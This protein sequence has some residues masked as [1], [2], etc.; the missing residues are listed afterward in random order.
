[1]RRLL[2]ALIH[3]IRE[4]RDGLWRNPALSLLSSLSI[5]AALYVVGLFFLIAFN[6]DGY[7]DIL[8]RDIQVQVYLKENVTPDEIRAL[9]DELGTDPAVEEVRHVSREEA[10]RR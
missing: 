9:R 6:L 3:G 1:M 5:G 7:V 4:A 10:Q 8:G 2:R